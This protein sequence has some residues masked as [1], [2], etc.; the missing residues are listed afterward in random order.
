MLGIT[1]EHVKLLKLNVADFLQY[2]QV[3]NY[4]RKKILMLENQELIDVFRF[5]LLGTFGG[6]YF[7]FKMISMRNFDDSANFVCD[8]G[9]G[10]IDNGVLKISTKQLAM[11]L[12]DDVLRNLNDNNFGYLQLARVMRKLCGASKFE[13]MIENK[14]CGDFDIFTSEKCT[15]VAGNLFLKLFA[16]QGV[17]DFMKIVS[18]SRLIN[19]FTSA[20]SQIKIHKHDHSPMTKLLSEYC[21]ATLLLAPDEF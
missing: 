5:L 6:I 4:V 14:K 13:E 11:K 15:P 7:D 12:I 18:H 19:L 8:S 17:D 9:Y 21:P 1:A 2:L 3:N 10:S 20:S 16:S